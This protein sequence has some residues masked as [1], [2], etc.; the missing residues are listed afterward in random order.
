MPL[1]PAKERKKTGLNRERNLSAAQE[2]ELKG[3]KKSAEV[4]FPP[5]ATLKSS[6]RWRFT[7]KRYNKNEKGRTLP[8]SCFAKMISLSVSAIED[9]K[10]GKEK[11][12][13]GKGGK[14]RRRLK[15][16]RGGTSFGSRAGAKWLKKEALGKTGE[17]VGSS[18]K[19]G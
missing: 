10:D 9:T 5:P 16:N 18:G 11:G 3:T 8:E 12:K 4:E 7:A 1:F 15:G 17:G 19:N 14:T 6:N 13:S 2:R